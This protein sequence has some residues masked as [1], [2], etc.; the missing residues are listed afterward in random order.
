MIESMLNTVLRFVLLFLRAFLFR[1]FFLL[2]VFIV[3]G[4]I[5]GDIVTCIAMGET[6]LRQSEGHVQ[7]GADN[8][9]ASDGE[10]R[11]ESSQ[12]RG[13][14]GEFSSQESRQSDT[15]L[16]E[17]ERTDYTEEDFDNPPAKQYPDLTPPNQSKRNT[18]IDI[19]RGKDLLPHKRN[20]A[21]AL[22]SR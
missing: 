10:L 9:E 13:T 20:R 6:P 11:Q 3:V 16:F 2:F 18:L 12:D 1:F 17:G 22:T 8:A 4:Y 5:N 14:T 7:A 19:Q 15:S 21:P